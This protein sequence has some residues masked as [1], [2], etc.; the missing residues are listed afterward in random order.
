MAYAEPIEYNSGRKAV[1]STDNQQQEQPQQGGIL[2]LNASQ[3]ERVS[4]GGSLDSHVGV[5]QA[6]TLNAGFGGA[7]SIT[8]GPLTR[9]GFVPVDSWW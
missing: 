5:E 8:S 7:L 9:L 2:R 3:L 1:N 4:G 6:F